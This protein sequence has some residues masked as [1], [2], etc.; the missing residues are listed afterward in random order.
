M[1]IFSWTHNGA[2]TVSEGPSLCYLSRQRAALYSCKQLQAAGLE[3]T[4]RWIKSRSFD[5]SELA[6]ATTCSRA[7]ELLKIQMRNFCFGWSVRDHATGS[8]HGPGLYKPGSWAGDS[9]LVQIPEYKLLCGGVSHSNKVLSFPVYVWAMRNGVASRVVRR[10][11]KTPS[12]GVLQVCLIDLGLLRPA[13]CEREVWPQ[14]WWLK[15][16]TKDCY[17]EAREREWMSEFWLKTSNSS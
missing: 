6:H 13:G 17:M 8:E 10:P 7:R 14:G 2:A 11:V 12:R 15:V 16:L 4:A 1:Q 9:S 5:V 3:K